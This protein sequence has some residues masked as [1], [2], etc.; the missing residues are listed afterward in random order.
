MEQNMQ[1]LCKRCSL[2][3]PISKMRYDQSGDN[4]ICTSCYE[5]LYKKEEAEK[6]Q[7]YQ[8]AVSDRVKYNCLSC[9]F[10]FSRS[11]EFSFGGLCFNC[12]KPTVQREDT[13]RVIVKD[14]KNLLDY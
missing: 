11:E 6:P 13:K 2:K 7:V 1:I 8:S 3:V 10:K 5:R 9:G 4:L 12:G 14:S